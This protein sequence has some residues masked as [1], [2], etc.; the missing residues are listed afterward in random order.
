LNFAGFQASSRNK[1]IQYFEGLDIHV[2]AWISRI[3]HF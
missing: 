2:N 1:N 3:R